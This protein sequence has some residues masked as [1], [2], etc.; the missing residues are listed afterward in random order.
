MLRE[1]FESVLEIV[2]QKKVYTMA[3]PKLF[4]GVQYTHFFTRSTSLFHRNV[5]QY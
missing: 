4:Q 3:T 2:I 1:N 5:S